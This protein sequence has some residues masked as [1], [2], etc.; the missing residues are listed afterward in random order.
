[1]DVGDGRRVPAHPDHDDP[2][3]RGVGLA[4]AAP[5]DSLG[6]LGCQ[7]AWLTILLGVSGWRGEGRLVSS[8]AL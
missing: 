1:V 3:Q 6:R 8:F 7:V 2:K 5:V 4:V